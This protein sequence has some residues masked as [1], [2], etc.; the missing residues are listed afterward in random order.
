MFHIEFDENKLELR[1]KDEM[2]KRLAE[3]EHRHTFWDMK[4][5]VRQTNMSENFIKDQFFYDNRFPKVRVGRKWVMPAKATEE[6]LL[7]WLSEQ[8]GINP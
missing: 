7:L 1:V 8:K 3:I 2:I 5:L 4:E 6:F